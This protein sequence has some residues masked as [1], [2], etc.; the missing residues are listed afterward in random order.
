MQKQ[1]HSLPEEVQ[2]INFIL[3]EIHVLATRLATY[4]SS[5]STSAKTKSL[6]SPYRLISGSLLVTNLNAS[7]FHMGSGS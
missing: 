5:D 1:D 3:E 6:K 2:S 4:V 7:M